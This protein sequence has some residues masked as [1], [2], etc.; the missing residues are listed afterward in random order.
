MDPITLMVTAI[1]AGAAAALK[2][3]AEQAVKDAYAALKTVIRDRY[4]RV[5]TSVETL[6]QKPKDEPRR[7]ILEEELAE[8]DAIMDETVLSQAQALLKA[9]QDHAPESASDVAIDI[10]RIKVGANLNIRKVVAE[11]RAIRIKDSEITND[12]NIEDIDTR[13]RRPAG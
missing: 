8:S 2:P 12:L 7:K 5:A 4:T 10:D 6:E 9:I 13:R 1:T 11:G 3:T